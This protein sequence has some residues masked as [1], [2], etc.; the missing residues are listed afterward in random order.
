MKKVVRH[1]L[2][3]GAVL[4]S[5]LSAEVLS[6]GVAE[7]ATSYT[8]KDA[9]GGAIDSGDFDIPALQ[10]AVGATPDGDFGPTSCQRTINKVVEQ[11]RVDKSTTTL[12]IG[13][14]VLGWLGINPNATPS[15]SGSPA[16]TLATSADVK[17]VQYALGV[18][19]D[20]K[21]GVRSCTKLISKLH[22]LGLLDLGSNS[23]TLT[24]SLADRMGVDND[25][26]DRASCGKV[27]K[28]ILVHAVL[29]K[30]TLELYNNGVLIDSTR[31]NTGKKGMRTRNGNSKIRG[32]TFGQDGVHISIDDRGVKLPGRMG[33]PH[34]FD[35][36]EAFHW[37]VNY[38]NGTVGTAM[39]YDTAFPYK[40][41]Q[42]DYENN[43]YTE[44][45][46]SHGCVHVP[47][48]FLEKYDNAYFISQVKVR[49]RDQPT[50]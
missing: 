8:C 11:G 6:P 24:D 48:S 13:P 42:P 38:A 27:G 31:V 49:I 7:A 20:G 36:G 9:S 41:W 29:G 35:G 32:E 45:F 50:D 47:H 37:R 25:S 15:A 43:N 12:K 2:L 23:V 28:C 33:D 30:N 46:A 21:F 44:N 40:Q 26:I 10:R 1:T 34:P 22:T 3:A 17:A 19:T 18:A 14:I 5:P 4:A 16:C 39:K